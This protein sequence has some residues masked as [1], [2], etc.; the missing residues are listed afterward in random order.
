[1]Q[2]VDLRVVGVH[3]VGE[4]VEHELVV[5]V[6]IALVLGAEKEI[7]VELNPAVAE[8]VAPLR[9]YLPLVRLLDRLSLGGHVVDGMTKTYAGAVYVLGRFRI[10]LEG[11]RAE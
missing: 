7:N 10:A 5:V 1:M 9:F 2:F 8:A 3:D 4:S 6:E 11:D